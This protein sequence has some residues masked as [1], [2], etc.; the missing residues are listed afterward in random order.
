M[1][2]ERRYLSFLMTLL[3]AA[4]AAKLF[5]GIALFM[6]APSC[7]T[8]PVTSK[9]RDI[10]DTIIMSRLFKTGR[11]PKTTQMLHTLKQI[12]LK[13]L[14]KKG[15]SGFALLSDSGKEI[16][17]DLGQN[18]KGYRLAE[19]AREYIVLEKDGKDYKLLLAGVKGKKE[20]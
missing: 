17:L 2:F 4:A 18:Y 10:S 9:N 20:R 5:W 13:A 15:R 14:F 16:Y 11:S 3:L 8:P 1:I 7:P 12:Q 6:I 19:I